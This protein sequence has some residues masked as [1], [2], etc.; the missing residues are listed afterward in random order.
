MK[1]LKIYAE[2]LKN[3]R[4]SE[5]T[6]IAY[7]FYFK[8]FLYYFKGRDYRYISEQEIKD[9]ILYLITE[10]NISESYQNSII[11]AIKFYYEHILH[12]PRKVYYLPRPQV[13]KKVPILLTDEEIIALFNTC[14]NIKHKSIMALLYGCG[15][16]RSEIINL[17]IQDIN[18]KENLIYIKNSKGK[19]D[20]KVPIPENILILLREYFKKYKPKVFLFNGQTI[21][22]IPRIQYSEQS[23]YQFLSDYAKLAGIK[24]KVYPHL[25]R[26][27]Y[28]TEQIE[29]DINILKLQAILGHNSPI[30]TN[31]YYG[32]RR[33]KFKDIKSP[34][35]KIQLLQNGIVK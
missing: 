28:A 34:I 22:G 32:Y 4:Y 10:K 27:N 23:M 18:G 26:H 2:E 30:T 15:L 25:L 6:I 13:P 7:T 17:K 24:K 12:Q 19:K 1:L 14:K 16:R 11:N 31:I 20:R 35:E 21:N 5:N 29:S 9:Y 8:S 3:R 33:D